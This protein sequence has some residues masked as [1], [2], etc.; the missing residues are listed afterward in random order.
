MAGLLRHGVRRVGVAPEW[1]DDPVWTG[2]SLTARAPGWGWV[3]PVSLAKAMDELRR[4]LT[5]LA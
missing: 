4:S 1:T 5:T 2:P 3:P